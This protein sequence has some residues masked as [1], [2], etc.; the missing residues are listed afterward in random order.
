MNPEREK[1][2]Q[3]KAQRY[4]QSICQDRSLPLSPTNAFRW[5]NSPSEPENRKIKTQNQGRNPRSQVGAFCQKTVAL[6]GS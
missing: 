4:D 6:H 2:K 3:G 5:L 1:E